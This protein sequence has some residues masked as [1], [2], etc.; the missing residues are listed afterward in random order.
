MAKALIF[1][2]EGHE[3]VEMLTVVDLLRRAKIEIAMVS[4]TRNKQVTSSHGVTLVAD[5]L[6]EEVDFDAADMLILPGGMPGTLN[7]KAHKQLGEQLCRFAQE[8]KWLAAVCAAPTV[9]GDLGILEGHK[10]TCFPGFVDKLVCG[11][12]VKQPVVVDGKVITSR[13]MGTCIEFGLQI[14]TALADAETAEQ[15]R[16]SIIYQDQYDE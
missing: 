1:L 9:L 14:I 5:A 8:G 16:T 11:Q 15:V 12:Y 6:I 13:G 7:L 3:E 10:A 2:A 4:I